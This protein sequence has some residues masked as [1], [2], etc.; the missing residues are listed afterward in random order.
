[1]IK[2]L[3]EPQ[4]SPYLEALDILGFCTFPL[5]C[6]N[7]VEQLLSLYH[8]NFSEKKIDSLY[9]T[10]NS[11]PV[12]QSLSISAAIKKIIFDPFHKIFPEYE[13]F[14]G[15]FIVKGAHV[16]KEFPLHQDWNI[17]EESKFK[18]YQ[19]WIPLQ[20]SYPANGGFF[21]IP[22]SHK[23]FQNYR[24]GSYGIPVVPFDETVK[25]LVND[26]IVPAGNVLVY[27]NGLFHASHPN[28]TDEIRIAVIANFVEKRA[29]TYYFHKNDAIGATELYEITGETLIAN[30][31]QLEKGIIDKSFTKKLDVA[32]SETTNS[33]ITSSDL[34]ARY[35]NKFGQTP[36]PQVKQLHIT[37][38]NSLEEV[39]N[40]DGYTVINFLEKEQIEFFRNEYQSLFRTLD[41]KPGRFTTLQDTDSVTKNRVHD[42]IV[43]HV[44]IPLR[45]YFR[46]FIIPVSQFYTKKAHTSGDID[47][48]SDTTL[49][50]NHQLE[51]HYAIWVPLL[52]VDEFNGTL[53]VIPRSHRVRGA[54]FSATIACYHETCIDW[55][56]QFEIPIKLKAG[57]AVIFDNNILHNSTANKT[58]TDRLCF[59]FRITHRNS[60]YYSFCGQGKNTNDFSI[61]NEKQNFYMDANWSGESKSPT[62]IYA[63]TLKNS[64]T[65]VT[66]EELRKIFQPT[67]SVSE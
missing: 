14:L 13:F 24:S 51:P 49:L 66:K 54:F 52:D 12:K 9:A 67:I 20:I 16:E 45:N 42:F 18:S 62:A 11:N 40:E 65:R 30:L 32:N 23:F 41:K 58:D 7:E 21:V 22:G 28:T 61:Y 33:Q 17:V 64:V 1:M 37:N 44:D 59:T 8:N 31:P 4:S 5:F 55:L 39:L 26:L 35:K 50:I 19:V 63:G 36:A 25:P 29:P 48:H 2:N 56:R 43:Q 38:N 34:V 53:T 15:H 60:Q 6:N 46:D 27:H 47:L 10:H 57:Q 3:S